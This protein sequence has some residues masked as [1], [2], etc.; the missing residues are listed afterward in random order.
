MITASDEHQHG[1]LQ[2]RRWL[3]AC[4][5]C[6]PSGFLGVLVLKKESLDWQRLEGK[7]LGERLGAPTVLFMGMAK[8][9]WPQIVVHIL[10]NLEGGEVSLTKSSSGRLE[11]KLS[12]ILLT[13]SVELRSGC[14]SGLVLFDQSCRMGRL[15]LET[16]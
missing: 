5:C 13:G 9:S 8:R 3:G 2:P 7:R 4:C 12:R 10:R 11:F 15:K 16:R 6:P 1:F 14:C